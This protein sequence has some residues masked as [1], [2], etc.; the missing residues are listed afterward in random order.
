M[1]FYDYCGHYSIS[2]NGQSCN[3]RGLWYSGDKKVLRD[4]VYK[5][6]P[7]FPFPR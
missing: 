6:S 5:N 7:V 3:L 2:N 4:V 1:G